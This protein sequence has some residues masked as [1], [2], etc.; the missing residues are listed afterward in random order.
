MASE[1]GRG[2]GRL[3]VKL[4]TPRGKTGDA[5]R[6][7]WRR[8]EAKP[9][10][11]PVSARGASGFSLFTLLPKIEKILLLTKCF[12]RKMCNLAAKKAIFISLQLAQAYT[13]VHK[14]TQA[15]TK[16][17]RTLKAV[18]LKKVRVQ[19]VC[20]VC[21]FLYL[22][23]HRLPVLAGHRHFRISSLGG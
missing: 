23:L 10:A 18:Q 20:S 7:N 2:E 16:K 1:G 22:K 3:E 12:V 4:E 19:S 21:L 5:S 13:G 17:T 9:E 14:R 8:L 11:S 6:Q 15:H